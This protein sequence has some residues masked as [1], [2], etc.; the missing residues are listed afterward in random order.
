VERRLIIGYD[1][2][3]NGEDALALGSA[4]CRHVDAEPL[5]V[6]VMSHLMHLIDS[7]ELGPAVE[8]QSKPL[9]AA[10]RERLDGLE[11][12]TRAFVDNSPARVLYRLAE[13]TRPVAIVIG[14]A[15]HGRLGRIFLGSVGTALLSGAPSPIAVAPRGYA[16][17]ERHGL[18]R[19]AVAFSGT[20][21]SWAALEAAIGLALRTGSRLT[22]LG[23]VEPVRYGYAAPYPMV[24]A[25]AYFDARQEDMERALDAAI[26]RLPAGIGSERRL[27]T[28]DP[29]AVIAEAAEGFDLLTVGS[30]AYGPIRR[31]LLG[32]VSARVVGSA[33]AP[34]L[35][36][37]RGTPE[38]DPL[39]L[40]E[41]ESPSSRGAQAEPAQ[42]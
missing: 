4:L 16:A 20:P 5:V 39:G 25:A 36:L 30:R 7:D 26:G 22:I 1:G 19:I 6:T 29:A 21:E 23:A 24:D 28:G 33:P 27:L 8:E 14:S 2:S 34:V 3:P 42:R 32:S 40:R 35:V 17:T 13:A 38:D 10:A 15:H 41:A 9:F 37:P 12:S 18:G 31:T 11:A